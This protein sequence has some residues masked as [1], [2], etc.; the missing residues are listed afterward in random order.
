V[1]GGREVTCGFSGTYA[2]GFAD[3]NGTALVGN[4]SIPFRTQLTLKSPL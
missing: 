3:L 4:F 2:D 1:F